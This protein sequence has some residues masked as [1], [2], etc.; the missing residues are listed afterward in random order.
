[1]TQS[2]YF[3]GVADGL[4]FGFPATASV[5]NEMFLCVCSQIYSSFC[6]TT[7][8]LHRTPEA[9][10]YRKITYVAV[11]LTPKFPNSDEETGNNGLQQ[12][13]G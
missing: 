6:K 9:A 4:L 5:Q 12:E 10:P 2:A 8:F 13:V 3:E 11:S 7:T 1:V